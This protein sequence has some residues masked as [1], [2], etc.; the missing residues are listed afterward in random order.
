MARALD[1]ERPINRAPPSRVLRFLAYVTA[2]YPLFILASLYGQWLLSWWILGHRP[3]PSL[4]DPKSIDGASW[5]HLITYLAL[6]GF[7]PAGCGAR[8]FNTFYAINRRLWRFRL[9]RHIAVIGALWLGTFL[10]LRWDPGHVLY[11]WFD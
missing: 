2:A 10:S 9:V 1:Y 5:M 4:D 11:W 7:V 8:V 6:G 3:V